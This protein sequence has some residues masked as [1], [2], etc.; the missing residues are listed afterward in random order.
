MFYQTVTSLNP[1]PQKK[2]L[3]SS[4]LK[5]FADDNLKFDENGR[6]FFIPAKKTLWEK[7]KLLIN[8]NFSFSHIGFKRS[9]L[10]TGENQVLFWKR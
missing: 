2:V 5:V 7:E 6:K 4:K 9:V 8:S 3:D 10:Q 1:F